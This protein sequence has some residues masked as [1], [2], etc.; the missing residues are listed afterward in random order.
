MQFSSASLSS[1]QETGMTPTEPCLFDLDSVPCQGGPLA[2]LAGTLAHYPADSRTNPALKSL[3]DCSAFVSTSE[4]YKCEEG[5]CSG[6][7][8]DARLVTNECRSSTC[9]FFQL[10]QFQFNILIKNRDL[11]GIRFCFTSLF[12]LHV[13][14]R[15]SLSSGLIYT[16]NTKEWKP[17]T[18]T[19]SRLSLW[20]CIVLTVFWDV[21][22]QTLP[23]RHQHFRGT[24]CLYLDSRI[25]RPQVLHGGTSHP[26]LVFCLQQGNTNDEL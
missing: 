4:L 20:L 11:S 26:F 13:W 10:K 17:L 19:K 7:V 24:R 23:H 18:P 1:L 9:F 6:K 21:T 25:G 22:P 2:I 16:E 12:A 8:T 14:L 15:K 5:F 3:Y